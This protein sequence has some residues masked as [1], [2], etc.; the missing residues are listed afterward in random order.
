M[1]GSGGSFRSRALRALMLTG[2]R[3]ASRLGYVTPDW[4]RRAGILATQGV[5]VVLDVGADIGAYA[6]EVRHAGYRGRIV[7]FEPLSR[8]YAKLVAAAAPDGLWACRRLAI[9]DED[10]TMR[11]NVSASPASSSALPMTDQHRTSA[12]GSD[13]V[14]AEQVPVARLDTIWNEVV[15]EGDRVFLKL[16][17]QGFELEALRGAEKSLGEVVGMQVELSLVPLFEGAPLCLEVLNYLAARGF[18]LAGF[19]EVFSDPESGEMLEVDGLF[20]RGH[21]AATESGAAVAPELTRNT[22]SG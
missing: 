13:Y 8:S 10:G 17:V 3:L 4:A 22:G 14:A 2:F 7:S 19:E 20:V 16:D 18:R 21:Q 6:R 1:S 12:P 5:T 11:M 9:G 15:R